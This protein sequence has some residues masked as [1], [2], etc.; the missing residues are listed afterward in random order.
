[1][2]KPTF[3]EI[4][5]HNMQINKKKETKKR[6]TGKIASINCLHINNRLTVHTMAPLLGIN[7]SFITER[8]TTPTY[9]V[10]AFHNGEFELIFSTSEEI[11]I[12]DASPHDYRTNKI[13]VKTWIDKKVSHVRE[14][15]VST[16]F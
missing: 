10:E 6:T 14:V 12:K 15:E 4:L 3:E 9:T 2:H 8:K 1:M 16:I 11:E 13:L 7:H 5:S